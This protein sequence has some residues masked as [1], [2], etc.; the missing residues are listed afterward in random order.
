MRHLIL[1]T[2]FEVNITMPL[3]I[4]NKGTGVVLFIV[5]KRRT[6]NCYSDIQYTGLDE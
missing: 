3:A 4:M 6:D 2:L 5:G 1:I